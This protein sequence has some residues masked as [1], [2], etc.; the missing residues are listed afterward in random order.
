MQINKKV[1][2]ERGFYIM[3]LW[4]KK[5]IEAEG[6][7]IIESTIDFLNGD[8]KAEA[9]Q[10]IVDDFFAR[11]K[12]DF[13]E[14]AKKNLHSVDAYMVASDNLVK[15]YGIRRK[16]DKNFTDDNM[17]LIRITDM[18]IATE[19]RIEG[20]K[21]YNALLEAIPEE[22]KKQMPKELLERKN[23]EDTIDKH[24][25]L[26]FILDKEKSPMPNDFIR[27][28]D[29]PT[30]QFAQIW[31]CCYLSDVITATFFI[32]KSVKWELG[33]TNETY[34]ATKT[35][36]E[37]VFLFAKDRIKNYKK[38]QLYMTMNKYIHLI[39]VIEGNEEYKKA[40]KELLPILSKMI[41]ED[42][43][44]ADKLMEECGQELFKQG[45]WYDD[46]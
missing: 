31:F 46:K 9:R 26:E 10:K 24:V 20:E 13:S 25:S 23:V 36:I 3:K 8:I 42:K 7:K 12:D 11:F 1:L 4:N 45:W 30:F 2:Y 16:A 14:G 6:K 32:D 27:L 38:T 44:D 22:A 43:A 34:Q 19:T 5:Q 37:R 21:Q 40:Q 18:I 33:T 35:N 28:F 29:N 15:L 39:D 41:K 17:T